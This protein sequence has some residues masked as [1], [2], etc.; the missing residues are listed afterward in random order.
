MG[1]SGKTQI[2]ICGWNITAQIWYCL[3]MIKRVRDKLQHYKP[4][5]VISF[6]DW[7]DITSR[8]NFAKAFLAEDNPASQIL[9]EELKNAEEIVITNRVH[10]V[11]EV[12]IIG[13]IQKI[14]TTPKDEQLDELVGQI[15]FIR[16]YIAELESWIYRKEELESLEA[17]G[18]ITIRRKEEDG[19]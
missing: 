9:R 4:Q 17:D 10:E 16:G 3:I 11:K 14:F 5:E 15:K 12:R 6:A 19:K 7:Q 18:K 2:W 13:E 8:F 1:K